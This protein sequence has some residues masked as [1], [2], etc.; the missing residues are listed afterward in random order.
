MRARRF[1]RKCKKH[2]HAHSTPAKRRFGIEGFILSLSLSQSDQQ[3]RVG[4]E[5]RPE[6][7]KKERTM[8]GAAGIPLGLDS[9]KVAPPPDVEAES[10]A[11]GGVGDMVVGSV[12]GGPRTNRGNPPQHGA[13]GLEVLVPKDEALP[14]Q[15]RLRSAHAR[16]WPD[17]PP[18]PRKGRPK[19]FPQSRDVLSHV[20]LAARAIC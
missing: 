20:A 12:A 3:G 17:F 19:G 5:S 6:K 8:K 7:K 14:Q 1:E 9:V 15:F 18:F 16:P 2:S 4:Q 11:V 13:S 10:E